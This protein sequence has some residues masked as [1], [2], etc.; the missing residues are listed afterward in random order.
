MEREVARQM[1][2]VIKEMNRLFARIHELLLEVEDASERKSLAR[3]AFE[4]AGDAHEKIALKI[5]NQY[6][7]MHPDNE[8][9]GWTYKPKPS[10]S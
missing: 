8:E 7:E 5:A 10:Q 1:I 3:A 4:V 6:P 9:G 2:D